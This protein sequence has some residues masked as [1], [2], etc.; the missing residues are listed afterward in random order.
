MTRSPK[1]PRAHDATLIVR[2]AA[3]ALRLPARRLFLRNALTLGGLAMLTGC[4]LTD[5][6]GTVT[7]LSSGEFRLLQAFVERPG[8]ILTR[9]QL[10]DLSH[11]PTVESFDRAID[12]QISRLRKKLDDGTGRDVIET[13]RGE[14]YRLAVSVRPV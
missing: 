7:A 11:G 1:N 9:D 13:V 12:V 4:E 2:E 5:Q 3:S 14:G 6:A 8:R 10:L